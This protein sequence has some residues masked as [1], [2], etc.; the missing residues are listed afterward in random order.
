MMAKITTG[1]NFAGAIKYDEGLLGKQQIF[2]TLGFEG[3]DMGVDNLGNYAPDVNEIAASFEIQASLNPRVSKPVKH[4][5][6]SW[7]P[8]DAETLTDETMLR[9]AQAYMKEMGYDNTQYLVTRH[10]GT[11]NPHCHIIVNAVDNEGKKINDRMER[12]RSVDVCK[13][14]T[15]EMG[16]SW[17]HHK[18]ANQSHIPRDCNQRTYE[19]A[20]YEISQNIACAIPQVKNIKD[21]PSVLLLNYGVV[22]DLKC[23]SK[24]K[25]C[26][27][28]FSKQVKNEDGRTVTC[29][30]SGSKIDRKF[31]CRSLENII[32]TWRKFPH[33]REEA[34]RIL[35]LYSSVRDDYILP[36]KVRQQCDAL[37]RMMSRLSKEERRLQ[38]KLP[39]SIAKGAIT[40]MLAIAFSTPLGALVTALTASVVVAYQNNK[41]ERIRDRK[42]S[43]ARDARTINKTF[44][45]APQRI[46]KSNVIKR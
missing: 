25:P 8:E 28:C 1:S 2:S 33:L 38:R 31:S 15:I 43:L 17:G 42:H 6:L 32:E 9:A 29:R 20:R 45:N 46:D 7:S 12:R 40:V 18:S 44:A 36:P 14:I 10:H 5:A 41:L 37:H 23:D 27:I 4:I 35:D 24:G 11:D 3:I 21:L 30:F 19:S 39:K 34:M 16:F 13:K 22:A 26:G